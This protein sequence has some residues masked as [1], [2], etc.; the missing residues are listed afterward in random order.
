MESLVGWSD[1]KGDRRE[2]LR[3]L[4]RSRNQ[5][6]AW[7]LIDDAA[8]DLHRCL[9]VYP[10]W[11]S[12]GCGKITLRLL[13]IIPASSCFHA[14]LSKC[15]DEILQADDDFAS[16]QHTRFHVHYS[17]IPFAVETRRVLRSME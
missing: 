5:V 14:L 4:M 1:P 11:A 7:C 16:Q 3:R 15:D 13:I 12:Q 6:P 9:C 8:L 10:I 17:R 2:V